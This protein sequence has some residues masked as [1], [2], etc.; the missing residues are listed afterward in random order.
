MILLYEAMMWTSWFL[1]KFFSFFVNA[2]YSHSQWYSSSCG[3]QN[4]L[5]HQHFL[6]NQTN[7]QYSIIYIVIHIILK[8]NNCILSVWKKNCII[9]VTTTR[10]AILLWMVSSSFRIHDRIKQFHDVWYPKTYTLE[11][12]PWMCVHNVIIHWICDTK[13][14]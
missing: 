11:I 13:V 7:Q 12:I 2:V 5:L 6:K 3:C 8:L 14:G 1:S 4:V 9:I 10:T